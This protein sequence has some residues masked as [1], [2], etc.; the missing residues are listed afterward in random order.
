MGLISLLCAPLT[1]HSL[2][3]LNWTSLFRMKSPKDGCR[4]F[5][6][7]AEDEDLFVATGDYQFE[8]YRLI[9]LFLIGTVKL[10]K[11]C[12]GDVHK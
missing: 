3:I 11:I 7:L 5:N 4:I 12:K 9:Q 1:D 10:L 8:I 2:F 6:N